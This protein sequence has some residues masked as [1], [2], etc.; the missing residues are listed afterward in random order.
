MWIDLY[1]YYI[2]TRFAVSL[3]S[4]GGIRNSTCIYCI[5]RTHVELLFCV[6]RESMAILIHYFWGGGSSCTVCVLRL[7]LQFDIL[8]AK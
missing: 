4:N 1:T 2:R 8:L 6:P 3:F 5:G 7:V